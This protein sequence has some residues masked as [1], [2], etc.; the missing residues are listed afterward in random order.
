MLNAKTFLSLDF[1]AGSLKLA[2]FEVTE[3]GGLRLKQFGFRA[4]GLLGAQDSVRENLLKKAF[5]E[6]VAKRPVSAKLTNVCA[7]GYQVFSKFI[8]LPP[9]DSSK[10][11]QIIQYEAQQNIPFPLNEVVWDY[12]KVGTASDGAMEVLLVAI[13]ADLVES[14]YRTTS[15]SGRN[16]QVVD[17]SVA[18]LSNAYRYTYGQSDE[19]VML[20]DIGAKTSNV[21]FFEK[22]RFFSRSLNIGANAITQEFAAEAKMAF[23]AAEQFKLSDGFVSLG[24]AYEE[25]DNPKQGQLSKIA[26]NVFTR[27]HI[28]INQTIQFYQKQNEGGTPSKIYLCGGGATLPYT[29]EF[30]TE[31]FGVKVEYFNPLGNVE[32]AQE[33]DREELQKVAH[34]M[35]ELIGLALRNLAECPLELNLVPL[36]VRESQRL[37]QKK[38]FFFA[39]VA[40]LVVGL[41]ALGWFYGYKMVTPKKAEI[42]D[43]ENKISVLEGP[44]NQLSEEQAK[45]E[46]IKSQVDELTKWVDERFFWYD[47]LCGL[48]DAATETEKEVTA[49]LSTKDKEIQAGLWIDEFL[50]ELPDLE[51]E[52]DEGSKDNRDSARTLSLMRRM[53]DPRMAARYGNLLKQSAAITGADGEAQVN[54][55]EVREIRLVC[56]GVNHNLEDSR[57]NDMLMFAFEKRV[58]GMTNL[59]D[60]AETSLT[61][62][63][64]LTNRYQNA[65][66]FDMKLKFKTP[67]KL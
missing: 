42:V 40:A 47:I 4:L 20:V 25:P 6:V 29:A 38:P 18:A 23:A 31:K 17:V 32:I 46:K 13:K 52:Q 63:D 49:A 2:E 26:R 64:T 48:Q 10:A 3:A 36:R 21:L 30:F 1:G 8:K 7:P 19:C 61:K 60:P 15:D 67:I 41:F 9:V 16:L 28:Q 44:A 5:G 53:F 45:V 50:P 35:G 51:T 65:F 43:F 22:G 62:Q 56:K 54:T 57:A 27:L 33:V 66:S 39:S 37:D 34:C 55:N 58:K 11:A 59:F 24:G 12:Q 14:L